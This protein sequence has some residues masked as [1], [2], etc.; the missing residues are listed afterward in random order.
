MSLGIDGV[1]NVIG[2]TLKAQAMWAAAEGD[3]ALARTRA[4]AAVDAARMKSDSRNLAAILGSA[5]SI[6]FRAGDPQA[7]QDYLVEALTIA[8]FA[9]DRVGIAYLLT[10]AARLFVAADDPSA[11]AMVLAGAGWDEGQPDTGHSDLQFVRADLAGFHSEDAVR[12]GRTLGLERTAAYVLDRL[13]N[14]LTVA[15]KRA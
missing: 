8:R 3:L 2:P 15:G 9:S 14:P 5:A 1:P 12:K 11:A 4:R 6:E 10:T 7:A 13:R